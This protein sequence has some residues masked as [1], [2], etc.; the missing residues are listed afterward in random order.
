MPRAASQHLIE[1]ITEVAERHLSG[2]P[3]EDQSVQGEGRVLEACAD[4]NNFPTHPVNK[5]KES[6]EGSAPVPIPD[7]LGDKAQK[8]SF[9]EDQNADSRDSKDPDSLNK[10]VD[11]ALLPPTSEKKKVEEVSLASEITESGHISVATP[12]FESDLLDGR[13]AATPSPAVDKLVVP[14]PKDPELPEPKDKIAEA[15][16]KMTEKSERKAPGEGNKEDK[17]R[18]AEPLKGYMR[19][20][21]SRGL[22]PLL[23]KSTAQERERAR[24]LKSGGMTLPWG[25]VCAWGF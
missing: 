21:K 12:E 10:E 19:P 11:R 15:P 17:S 5:K 14:P 25:R 8:P 6:E 7:L 2:M 18:V 22:T 16:D 13:A 9:S 3:V 4:R 20:T 24:Q 1:K 23:P